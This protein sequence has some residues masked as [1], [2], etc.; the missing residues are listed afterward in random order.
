MDFEADA[1]VFAVVIAVICSRPVLVEK[2]FD[3]PSFV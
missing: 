3:D 1:I 2:H